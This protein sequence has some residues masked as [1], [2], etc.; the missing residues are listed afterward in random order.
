MQCSFSLY[1]KY[2]IYWLLSSLPST[3]YTYSKATITLPIYCMKDSLQKL[4]ETCFL[5]DGPVAFVIQKRS[6]DVFEA[7]MCRTHSEHARD[8]SAQNSVTVSAANTAS[9]V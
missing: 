4:S 1:S 5:Y 9:F 2:G 8:L 6:A 7:D 3:E